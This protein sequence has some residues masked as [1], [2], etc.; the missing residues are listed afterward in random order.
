MSL[1]FRISYV[2]EE[3]HIITMLQQRLES[4]KISVQSSTNSTGRMIF[5]SVLRISMG[6]Y[7]YRR[8]HRLIIINIIIIIII[9]IIITVIVI[10]WGS[11]WWQWSKT[12]TT[13]V[14]SRCDKRGA[15]TNQCRREHLRD[16]VQSVM[17]GWD[18]N[19]V[20]TKKGRKRN[21]YSYQIQE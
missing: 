19:A 10:L 6:D 20:T 13:S 9:I 1:M 18:T 4:V 12:E 8:R 16:Q 7:N 2:N 11:W 15:S 3:T 14:A 17:F 5:Q 21:I